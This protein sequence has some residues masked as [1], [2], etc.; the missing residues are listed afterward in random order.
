M[1]ARKP[2]H[3]TVDKLLFLPLGS[4][5]VQ[6][7]RYNVPVRGGTA[8]HKPE[9]SVGEK[10]EVS[11][12]V[13]LFREWSNSNEIIISVG[14]DQEELSFMAVDLPPGMEPFPGLG[15]CLVRASLKKIIPVGA[16]SEKALG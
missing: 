13:F 15:N 5:K 7:V 8:S 2:F 16:Q 12:K 10:F 6:V 1:K 9:S 11:M 14:K 4:D 3:Q